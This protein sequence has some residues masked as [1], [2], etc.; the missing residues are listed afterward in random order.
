MDRLTRRELKQDQLRT[1]FEAFEQFAKTHYREIV[2]VMSALIVILGLAAG[3]K[4]YNDRQE[5]RARRGAQDFP[6]LRREC[7]AGNAGR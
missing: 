4:L 3:L 7:V 1:T 5:R 6:G 2:T